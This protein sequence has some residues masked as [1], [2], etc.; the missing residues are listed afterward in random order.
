MILQI[1]DIKNNVHVF[2]LST[3]LKD[4][5]HAKPHLSGP[6]EAGGLVQKTLHRQAASCVLKR[7][8]GRIYN[9]IVKDIIKR[10][11]RRSLIGAVFA[12]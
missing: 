10:E 12:L 1:P 9:Y 4:R 2:F 3:S 5:N 6:G 8:Q 11:H 7:S